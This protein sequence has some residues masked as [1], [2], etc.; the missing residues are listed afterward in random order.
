MAVFL[1]DIRYAIR[2][3]AKSPGFTA[4]VVLTLALGIGAN[5][6]IFS[7]VNAVLLRPLPF[8]N[9]D[10]LVQIWHRPPQASFPGITEFAV[11]PANFLDWR[12]ESRTLEGM[13]AYGFG[14]YILTGTG[15]P[16]SIRVC[17]ATNGLFSILRARPILGSAFFEGNND[18][19]HDHQVVLSYGI[20]RDRFGAD[21]AILEKS[22]QLNGQAFAVIGVMGPG[23]EFPISSDPDSRPQMW[24][25][26]AWTD[27]ERAV[28]DDHNYDVVARLKDGVSLK[29]AQAEL[30]TI[31]NQLA[32]QYPQDDKGWGAIVV[33]MR[34][35]LVGDVRASLEILLGA[36]GFVLLIACANVANLLLAKSLARRKESAIRAAL[37]AS[38]RRLLQLTFL[39]TLLLSL[40]GGALGLFFAHFGLIFIAGYLTRHLTWASS[41]TLDGRVLAFTA[42][43]CVLTA[44]A[45]GLIPALR[46]ATGDLNEALK[47]G[48]GRTSS[49]SSG[50]RTR[51]ALVISEVALSIT[52]LIGAGL[53]IRTLWVLHNVHPGF[54]PGHVATLDVSISSG[55]FKG[56]AEQIQFY[57]DALR[58]IRAITSVES[59]G[60]I[61]ALPLSDDGSRQ[62]F[63]IEGRPPAPMADLPEVEVR[64]TSP[65]Y[66][67]AMKIPVLR[68]RDL[69]ESDDADHP[70]AVLISHSMAAL[71]WPHEDP[72][73]KR[74]TLYF[75][76]DQPR[77]VVGVVGDVRM[78][79]MNETRPVPALY[80][81]LAQISVPR[82]ESW[83]SFSM[84]F[85][86]RS[87]M[88]PLAVVPAVAN[89]LH[90]VDPDV[91]VVNIH[92]MEDLIS[93]SLAPTRFTM[94]LLGSFAGLA[95]LLAVVGIYSVMSYTV[96][97]RTQEIGIRMAFGAQRRD[98]LRLVFE[99][100]A[101]MAL[102]G[103]AG[104]ILMAVALTRFLSS[105]LYGITA[106]D[107]R[108]FFV[109]ALL[110]FLVVVFACALPAR[111]ATRVDPMIALRYE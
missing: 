78:Y 55:K 96:S 109:V 103:I 106:L 63:S 99:N 27:Q 34:D 57:N 67:E 3:L 53:L 1:Q 79:A 18:P 72:I 49:D 2:L 108:T 74:L 88:D 11:S 64:L 66:L 44:L 39:E 37:G 6:A 102:V 12:S 15:R 10:R 46:G 60:I 75:F 14:R 52:L 73:G 100:G 16:E 13:S 9:P 48:V 19:G 43:V 21:P 7:V 85:D 84:T 8:E 61:D 33:P 107:P 77:V 20:W 110:V 98:V 5:T 23:F 89:S 50:N 82:G 36:V 17:A 91:P 94:F 65:G 22:I 35:D 105:Q 4:V 81:P 101:R 104:G 24:K 80:Y 47:Q 71:Y 76:P 95:L 31:S 62:P 29:Q 92:R 45:A 41:L 56:P 68:G 26:L 69:S 90:E 86:I 32:Q 40:A 38:R 59:V 83:Q 111:R 30:D 54:D 58:R 93:L 87:K 51:N 97:R 42:G 70:G 28:R 25:P